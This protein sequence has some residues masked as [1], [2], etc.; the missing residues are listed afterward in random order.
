MVV[1]DEEWVGSGGHRGRC[2]HAHRRLKPTIATMRSHRWLR[3]VQSV[4][5]SVCLSSVR[6]QSA[7]IVYSNRNSV[8]EDV[9]TFCFD[10]MTATSDQDR[11]NYVGYK[12]VSK[13]ERH[14]AGSI[15]RSCFLVTVGSTR[16]V[17]EKKQTHPTKLSTWTTN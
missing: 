16:F 10:C 4:C 11:K 7:R 1:V 8:V 3:S 14:R 6:Y 15:F 12:L 17:T 13:I 5:L 9:T 2:P